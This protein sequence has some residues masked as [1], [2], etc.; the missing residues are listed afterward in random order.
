GGDLTPERVLAAYRQGIFPWYNAEDPILWW[1]PDPRTVI[2]P[3]QLHISRSLKKVLAKARYRVT[4]DTAFSNVIEA[5]AQTREDSGT[6]INPDIIAAYS[7]LHRQG[8][9]HSVEVWH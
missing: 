9:A 4:L 5:C 8:F 1:S 7:R 6:W 2:F 3:E